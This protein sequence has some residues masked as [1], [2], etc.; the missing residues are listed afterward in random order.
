MT[1]PVNLGLTEKSPTLN[2]PNEQ[3]SLFLDNYC[4]P[5]SETFGNLVSSA[6][7][8]GF[9]KQYSYKLSKI[10]KDHIIDRAKNIIAFNSIKALKR[11]EDTLDDKFTGTVDKQ[12]LMV[13]TA[14]DI[15][16]RAGI[17]KKQELLNTNPVPI[18]V[19]ILPTQHTQATV[20]V[21]EEEEV[22]TINP[23]DYQVFSHQ[24]S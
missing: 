23:E 13:T 5:S 14:Q 9:A 2:E 20:F 1:L 19:V 8:S 22:L 17:S 3:Q 11:I 24:D 7:A 18:A 6:E 4:N 10:L 12:R 21:P 15:L 16:D